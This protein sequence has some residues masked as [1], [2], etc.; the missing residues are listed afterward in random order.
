MKI[1]NVRLTPILLQPFVESFLISE[2]VSTA[3]RWGF[4][5]CLSHLTSSRYEV[6]FDGFN[7]ISLN[8]YLPNLTFRK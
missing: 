7:K 8:L 2:G 3:K 5:D 4:R 1:Q 6:Q